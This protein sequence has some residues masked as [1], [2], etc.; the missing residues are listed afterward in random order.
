MLEA[1]LDGCDRFLEDHP[2][3]RGLW[4]V[5]AFAGGIVAWVALPSRQDWIAAL[6][7]AGATAV[8]AVLLLDADRR[9][10]LRMAIAGVAVM[11]AAGLAT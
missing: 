8:L 11:A 10:H 1:V 6:L 9:P 7:G 2:F 4:L 5:V 3:E